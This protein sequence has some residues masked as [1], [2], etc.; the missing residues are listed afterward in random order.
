VNRDPGGRASRGA[1]NFL[2][3]ALVLAVIAGV[4]LLTVPLAS[5][6]NSRGE[7][8]STTLIDQ[9][10]SGVVSVLAVPVIITAVAL[11]LDSTR[12]ASI[13]RLMGAFVMLIGT[14][15]TIASIGI[16][17][18]PSTACSVVAALRRT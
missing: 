1:R 15:V 16:L 9:E 2:I 3:A 12:Y 11:T 18:I 17:Y 6:E 4:I 10:G 14:F 5:T 8:T 13:G 7:R